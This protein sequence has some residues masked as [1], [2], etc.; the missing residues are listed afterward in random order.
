MGAMPKADTF[1]QFPYGF[2]PSVDGLFAQGNFGVVTK[3]G[4]WLMPEPESYFTGRVTVRRR[5]DLIPLVDVVNRL[6]HSD[7]SGLPLYD[8]QLARLND[9]ELTALTARQDVSDDALDEFYASQR[10]P[11]LNPLFTAPQAWLYRSFVMIAGFPISRTDPKINEA[12]RDS[13]M[14]AL[15]VAAERGW[16][17]YRTTPVF[18][19]AVAN[20]YSFNNHALRRFTETLK[21][22]ADP[23]GI[24]APGRGG[25]WPR[26][27]RKDNV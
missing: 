11:G 24:L 16:A 9:S 5:G 3:M 1:G 2:G 18:S 6:E 7:L 13:F 27:L 17:E 15:K 8:S 14:S 12:S 23:N 22:A 26:H 20:L 19:D 25:I 4:I 10:I 21:D